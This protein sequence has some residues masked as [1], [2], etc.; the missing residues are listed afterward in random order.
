MRGKNHR[1]PNAPSCP[2][3]RDRDDLLGWMVAED[4]RAI[5]RLQSGDGAFDPKQLLL[6]F[7]P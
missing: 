1:P 6:A 3:M 7:H 5:P 2:Q 4:T